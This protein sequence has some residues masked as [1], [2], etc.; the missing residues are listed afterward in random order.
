MDWL[1]MAR[2]P[3]R[4]TDDGVEFPVELT[5]GCQQRGVRCGHEGGRQDVRHG[6]PVCVVALDEQYLDGCEEPGED[7]T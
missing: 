2:N 6:A 5:G 7:E 1:P 4:A 3:C